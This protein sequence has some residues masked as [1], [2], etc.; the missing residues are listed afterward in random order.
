[1]RIS[2]K[3]ETTLKFNSKYSPTKAVIFDSLFSFFLFLPFSSSFKKKRKKRNKKKKRFFFSSPSPSSIP[4][5]EIKRKTTLNKGKRNRKQ[6]KTKKKKKKR[7][8]Q[9]KK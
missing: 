4:S 7:I 5:W 9:M 3:V 2:A 1:M 8:R 6:K